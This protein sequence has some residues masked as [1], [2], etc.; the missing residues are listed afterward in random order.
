[1]KKTDFC[2]TVCKKY[3]FFAISFKVATEMHWVCTSVYTI[4]SFKHCYFLFLLAI[5]LSLYIPL[6]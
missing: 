3:T 1:M 4:A 5:S 2:I 6:T